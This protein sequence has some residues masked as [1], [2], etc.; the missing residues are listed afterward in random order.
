LKR[1]FYYHKELKVQQ[2]ADHESCKAFQGRH[3]SFKNDNLY[4]CR[5]I[6]KMTAVGK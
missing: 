2:A 4:L 3:R 6:F 1:R 5:L